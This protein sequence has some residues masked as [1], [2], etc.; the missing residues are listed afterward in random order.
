[1]LKTVRFAKQVMTK[2]IFD[3]TDT[4]FSGF[5]SLVSLNLVMSCAC[6]D[7]SFI[8]QRCL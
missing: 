6:R 4:L 3:E 7:N 2:C 1:M 5:S 8:S